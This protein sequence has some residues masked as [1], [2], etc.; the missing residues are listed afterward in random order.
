MSDQPYLL[1]N[2]WRQGRERLDAVEAFLDPGTIR[3]LSAAG[4]AEG[5]RCLEIGAGG[6]SIAA[7]LSRR[8]GPRGHVVATDI[9][10]RFLADAA[11]AANVEARRHDAV[12]DP[13]EEGAFD[14]VHARLVLEHI[15]QRALVL[16]KL[17]KALKPGGRLV[18]ESVDYVS[19]V[20]VSALGADEHKRTQ[21]ARLREFAKAGVRADLGR[22]L[23]AMMRAEGLTGIENEGRVFV[24]EGGSPG[25]LWFKLSMQ[26]LRGR[27][28]GPDKL[29]AAQ[30]DQMLEWFGDPGWAAL[31]PI[32]FACAGRAPPV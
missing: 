9:D 14:L 27:L 21:E 5:W 7:W 3:A 19:A 6:G 18:L 26:Q 17:V 20:P 16:H 13:L 23:P 12:S 1:D 32:I 8:V 15:P 28:T 30:I 24:M 22:H 2:A 4:V 29:S 10:T 25:A 31:S 11:G